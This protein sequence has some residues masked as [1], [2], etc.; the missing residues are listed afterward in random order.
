MV[1]LSLSYSFDFPSGP[2]LVC[3]FGGFLVLAAA[4]RYVTQATSPAAA[5]GRVL[6]GASCLILF[7]GFALQTGPSGREDELSAASQL[8]QVVGALRQLETG[9]LD[10]DQVVATL[11]E[12]QEILED[13]LARQQIEVNQQMVQQ[14]GRLG[15]PSLIPIL[16][17]IHDH[18]QEPWLHYWTAVAQLELGDGDAIHSLIEILKD[19]TVPAFLKGQAAER[20]QHISGQDYGFDPNLGD[21]P[22]QPAVNRMEVWWHQNIERLHWNPQEQ[23]FELH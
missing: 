22:N 7:F 3:S 15:D 20:F 4:V 23:L 8:E 10:P 13:G 19:S 11:L 6:A 16:K 18:S 2:A 5:L 12:N 9:V 14:M 21:E 1:G 17:V